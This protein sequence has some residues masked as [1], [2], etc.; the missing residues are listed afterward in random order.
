MFREC[1]PVELYDLEHDPC[2]LR[3]LADKPEM[4]TVRERLL[5]Q[6]AQWREDTN[7][8]TR[9]PGG[10]A[11]LTKFQDNA[12]ASIKKR[13]QKARKQ[14]KAEKRKLSRRDLHKCSQ[15][16]PTYAVPPR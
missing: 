3:N 10:L 14:A 4:Q 8:P 15:I 13:V 2:E 5:K 7:D 6:L 12:T 1:V 9:T 16:K 11:A